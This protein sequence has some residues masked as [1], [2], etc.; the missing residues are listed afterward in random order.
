M[1]LVKSSDIHLIELMSWFEDEAQI[2]MWSGS[3]FCYPY[4]LGTF[5]QNLKLTSLPS[6]SLVSPQGALQAFGQY[7]LREQR[8]HLC[9]LVVNPANRGLGIV[10]TLI[11]NLAAR[12][13]EE[14][15]VNSCSL[16]VF[17]DNISAIR[18]YQKLG[19]VQTQYPTDMPL[20]GC[21]YMVSYIG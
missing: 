7:Y 8:C 12:G 14:F 3:G 13:K 2:V 6:F 5:K 19:F 4:D 15:K 16:F 20:A 11:A 17:N 10:A 21:T 1:K 9:R 18:A